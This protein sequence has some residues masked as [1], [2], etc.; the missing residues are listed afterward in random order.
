[1]LEEE[2]VNLLKSTG[3]EGIEGLIDC[4]RIDGFFEAPCSGGNHLCKVGGLAEHSLNVCKVAMNFA[5]A[6]GYEN[7]ESVVIVSLLHDYGKCGD[8]GKKYY[9]D[10]VLKSGKPSNV[11]PYKRNTT[12]LE[13]NH[14]VNSVLLIREVFE[15]TEEE[16]FAI[17]HHDGF[18][19]KANYDAWQNP[20]QLLMILHWADLW[21][22][23]VIEENKDTE[24][25]I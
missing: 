7:M 9:I 18:Y 24:E 10:N 23:R 25:E 19:E 17:L 4:L 14:A 12:L 20:T 22:A 11:K 3:R 5:Q 13:K 8:F 1:M 2:I 15:I 6:V 16:Q 21:S